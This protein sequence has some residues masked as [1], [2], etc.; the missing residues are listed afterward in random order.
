MAGRKGYVRVAPQDAAEGRRGKPAT[1]HHLPEARRPRPVESGDPACHRRARRVVR[2]TGRRRSRCR[3][4][5]PRRGGWR[6]SSGCRGSTLRRR[7]CAPPS[8]RTSI[9]HCAEGFEQ[10]L[11]HF[12]SGLNALSLLQ[13]RNS[14]ADVGARRVGAS[15]SRPPE[16][17][18]RELSQCRA[19]FDRLA[20]AVE[21]SIA[22]R[23]TFLKHQQPQDTEQLMWV[24]I[25][26]ADHAFLTG[27]KPAAVATR[28]REALATAP[29]FGV[30]SA[31]GQLEI[32][33]GSASGASSSRRR[34]PPSTA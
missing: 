25:S 21:M 15:R 16:D 7:R 23:E 1:G 32:F 4:A 3:A 28:Y 31:R 13:I 14:L 9:E 5:T 2:T 22:A 29:S 19:R 26:R 11:N 10:D 17:A 24:A 27:R 20:N 6:N 34:S 30:A 12:Y 18:A 8:S 33:R